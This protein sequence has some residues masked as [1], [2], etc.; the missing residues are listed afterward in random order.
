MGQTIASLD[1][2][3][4]AR[5]FRDFKYTAFRLETLQRY[6]VTY[7]REAFER[8]L[9][10]EERGEFPGIA[11][12]IEGTVTPAITSGKR[13]H[14]VHVVELPLSDYVRFESGWA[15]SHTAAAGEEIRILP[16][17]QGE[18]PTELPHYDYW[19]FDSATVLSM[20]YDEQ[21]NFESAEFED[22]PALIVHA[23][24]WRDAAVMLSIPYPDFA[25]TLIANSA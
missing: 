13:L 5:P 9:A 15:Y 3:E 8:F 4:F 20:R 11:E 24:R 19:L 25:E 10:G 12:W 14:R 2:P 16:V 18:W 23:N 6:A 22:D 1:D 17:R 21:G 7:E